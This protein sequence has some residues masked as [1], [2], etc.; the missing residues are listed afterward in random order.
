VVTV[1]WA[2]VPAFAA[3][4]TRKAPATAE[5]ADVKNALR[6]D[7]SACRTSELVWR[8]GV[9][10]GE[11]ADAPT[12]IERIPTRKNFIIRILIQQLGIG[13]KTEKKFTTTFEKGLKKR[14]QQIDNATFSL[15]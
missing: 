5:A 11:N 9:N 14:G 2:I 6:D 4:A 7:A 10:A 8:Q 1:L 15:T 12:M 13:Q 3:G